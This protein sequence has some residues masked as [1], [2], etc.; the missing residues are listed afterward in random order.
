MKILRIIPS[1][2]RKGG[3]PIEGAVQLTRALNQLGHETRVVSMDRPGTISPDEYPFEVHEIGPPISG[4][5]YCPRLVP[6]IKQHIHE[7]DVVVV[8][9]IWLYHSFA[10]WQALRGS[11]V[12]YV[13]YTHGMLDPWFKTNYPLKHLK[14]WC[15]WPWADYR[16]LRDAAAVC[17]TSQ[18]E[19][20]L[21]RQSFWL[22]RANEV[23]VNYGIG[24][25]C[26]D[27]AANKDVFLARY[28]HLANRRLLLYLSRI[29]EK[30]GIDLLIDAFAEIAKSDT[31]LVIAG[32]DG[33]AY[34]AEL[35][36]LIA[37]R[38][39]A[40]RV[41]W[42]GMLTGDV[43]FSAFCAADAFVLP[44]HQENF[45]IAVAEALACGTP[46]LITDKVNIWQD[47]VDDSAGLVAPDTSDGIA[48]LLKKWIATAPEE[49]TA[50]RA[51]ARACFLKRY[52]IGAVAADFISIMRDIG[53]DTG[54]RRS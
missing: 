42:T 22:Y 27:S 8:H 2:D 39:L 20:L 48:E 3:G 40:E 52:E 21:A 13:V 34:Q 19:K 7:Y 49:A 54:G 44:S 46:V 9:G 6:W 36:N 32:P 47:I 51:N 35:A 33:G 28:P 41:T 4:Y 45:G 23:V 18:Q 12:P 37:K 53:V 38:G 50:M 25:P 1:A 24:D 43:K 14:K 26:V 5:Y 10:A 17:F 29:H 30:K 31:H 15:F 11:S 16:V